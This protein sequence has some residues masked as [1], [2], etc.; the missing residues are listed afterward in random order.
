M[1]LNCKPYFVKIASLHK[2]YPLIVISQI[3]LKGI[4]AS[5]SVSN[6]HLMMKTL[7]G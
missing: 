4:E 1:L 7:I 5:K 6:A 3:T 2:N